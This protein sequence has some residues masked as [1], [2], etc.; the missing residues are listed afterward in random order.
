MDLECDRNQ[1]ALE[2]NI[3]GWHLDIHPAWVEPLKIRLKT[4]AYTDSVEHSPEYESHN[5]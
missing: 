2:M 1:R 4:I 5:S 3:E